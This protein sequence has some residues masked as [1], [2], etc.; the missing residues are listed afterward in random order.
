MSNIS[1]NKHFAMF[2]GPV[3]QSWQDSR[4]DIYIRFN[5]MLCDYIVIVYTLPRNSHFRKVMTL[6]HPDIKYCKWVKQIESFTR[7]FRLIIHTHR[8]QHLASVGSFVRFLLR[9]NKITILVEIFSQKKFLWIFHTL[10]KILVKKFHQR[11]SKGT[12]W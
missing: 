12:A 3:R 10:Q 2:Y 1:I 8:Q 4:A 7:G 5:C 11:S 6:H 9:G